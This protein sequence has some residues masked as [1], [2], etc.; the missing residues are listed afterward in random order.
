[1]GKEELAAR[2]GAH[3]RAMVLGPVSLAPQG[4]DLPPT[5]GTPRERAS[6]L[7]AQWAIAGSA[8]A[9]LYA[10]ALT[11][12]RRAFSTLPDSTRDSIVEAAAL[13]LAAYDAAAAL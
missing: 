13:Y 9:A 8:E 1:M 12:D 4:F 3:I 6:A 2:C 5:G 7:T 10:V 11:A